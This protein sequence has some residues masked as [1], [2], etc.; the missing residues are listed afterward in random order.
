MFIRR[1]YCFVLIFIINKCIY[2][3]DKRPNIEI[4]NK[5][6]LQYNHI[7]GED[8]AYQSCRSVAPGQNKFG[9][10][11]WESSKFFQ[12]GNYRSA[13]IQSYCNL[14]RFQTYQLK[15]ILIK[16]VISWLSPLCRCNSVVP[17]SDSF[18]CNCLYMYYYIVHTIILWPSNGATWDAMLILSFCPPPPSPRRP[19]KTDLVLEVNKKKIAAKPSSLKKN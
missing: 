17:F 10:T 6:F 4:D 11:T 15:T 1:L 5:L 12:T 13:A 18:S 2:W 9:W 3:F 8:T 14:C 19:R 7:L 16:T